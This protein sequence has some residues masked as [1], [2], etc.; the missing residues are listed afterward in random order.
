MES[1]SEQL[2]P[3][4]CFTTCGDWLRW[5]D[6][7]KLR[8]QTTLHSRRREQVSDKETNFTW[9]LGDDDYCDTCGHSWNKVGLE[10][11]DEERG[12]W[13]LWTRI[14][15]TGG[16]GVLSTNDD[17]EAISEDIIKDALSFSDFGK[18]EEKELRNKIVLIKGEN[19]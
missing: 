5:L 15:C 13:Q 4:K 2:Q 6:L 14:G 17:W 9:S 11:W 12:I 3:P 16:E 1:T 18:Q 19:K 8:I 10:L 7:C